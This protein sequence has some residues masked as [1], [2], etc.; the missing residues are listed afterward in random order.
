M[1]STTLPRHING[2]IYIYRGTEVVDEES[3]VSFSG[4]YSILTSYFS[5]NHSGC[6]L[7]ETEVSGFWS[8]FIYRYVVF[9]CVDVS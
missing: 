3:P 7:K 4:Q 2:N 5:S 1:L 9:E 6:S 8:C